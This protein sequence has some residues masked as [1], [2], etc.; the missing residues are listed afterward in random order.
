M[1][2]TTAALHI[3]NKHPDHP[4]FGACLDAMAP[5]DILLLIENGVLALVETGLQ[6]PE[7]THALKAD[8]DARGLGTQSRKGGKEVDYTGMITLTD[9]FSRLI[10]W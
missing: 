7:A 5:G 3:L 2:D 9:R 1:T 6:L 4:R 10:S 8:C